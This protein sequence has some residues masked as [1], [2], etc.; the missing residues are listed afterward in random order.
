MQV[1]TTKAPSRFEGWNGFYFAEFN[2]GLYFGGNA[3][4]YKAD[5]TDS[6]S[7]A[8]IFCDAQQAFSV[9]NSPN[10]KNIKSIAVSQS[11]SSL[12]HHPTLHQPVC[13]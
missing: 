3:E 12:P 5:S 4:I 7:G 13:Y 10:K 8:D 9:L 2:G 6:D 1:A 11:R